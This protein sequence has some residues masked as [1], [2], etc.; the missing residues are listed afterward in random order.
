MMSYRWRHDW[1]AWGRILA[2][3]VVLFAGLFGTRVGAAEGKQPNILF[4][5]ADDWGWPHA[6]AY[7][8]QV[9]KTPT[10]D[11]LAREGALFNHAYVSAPSCTPSRGAVLTGQWH[12][13]LEAAGN[14]WSVFPD[15]FAT[16]PELL[17][18][19]GYEVGVTGKGWGPGRT[20]TPNRELAGKRYRNF[21]AFLQERQKG[22]P[23]CFWL[24]SSDPHRP[25]KKG[26][27]AAAGLDL[28]R[29][30]LF[31][32]FPDHPDVR[33]DVADYYFEVQR[34]DRLVGSALES[35]EA[36]GELDNTVVLMTSDN[37]MPFP[38]SKSNLYDSGARMP[39]AVRWPG[40]VKP[41][42]TVDDFVSFTDFAPTFLEIAGLK[43]TAEMTGRSL[44]SVLTS[45]KSGRVDPARDFVLVG[46]ERHCPAQEQP[47]MGGYPCRAIRTHEFL[48]IRN[49]RPDR[50]PAGTPNYEQATFKNAWFGDC[51]NSPTKSYMVENR[52]K[53]AAHRRLYDLAFA[54][55]PAEELY[56]LKKDPEQLENVAAD[57]GYA[58]IRRQLAERL[59]DRL[60]ATGDPRAVGGGE[61]FDQYPYLGGA[62]TYPGAQRAKE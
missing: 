22:K 33:S 48:Y 45:E 54:K 53:D 41:G 58:A 27:G 5:I 31:A 46:K 35:L 4:A 8:D 42:R 39:L 51:D 17:E 16:Y 29:V 34:F 36:I 57:P 59:T 49:F 7:G 6:G 47:D 26:S 13:R 30:H 1:R 20:E 28:D 43:P 3:T 24:G 12:W 9:V 52:D 62:P 55:R 50:W 21:Q 60:E 56:D 2:V 10:F 19:A 40:K 15:K 37:G 14:L 25:Y 18:A 44:T 11:R 23:F 32:C 61:K 38:R